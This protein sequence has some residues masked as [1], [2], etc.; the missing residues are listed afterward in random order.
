MNLKLP[1]FLLIIFLASLKIYAQDDYSKQ[2]KYQLNRYVLGNIQE[3]VYVQ[4]NSTQ[5]CPGDTIW[6]KASLANAINHHPV[7]KEKLLYVD[8][9]SPENKV[10]SHLLTALD[11]GFADGCISLGKKSLTGQYKLVAYTNYMRNFSSDFFFQKNIRVSQNFE[12]MKQW[13]FNPTVVP[14][15]GG[16]SLFVKMYS[17][18]PNEREF[19]GNVDISLQLARG[20]MFG[21]NCMIIGNS[22]SFSLFVPDSLKTTEALL[23]VKT[24]DDGTEKYRVPLTVI[25]PDLQFMPEG[26]EL[27]PGQNNRLA[28]RCVDVN[29]NPLN[30]KGLITDDS[31]QIT[32]PFETEYKGM[33]SMEITPDAG[34]T[35]LARVNYRDSVFTY[36]LP[37]INNAAFSIQLIRQDKDSIHF[38]LL[39]S[40]EASQSYI[41]FGH[42]RGIA[43]YTVSGTLEKART[44]LTV[45]RSYFPEGIGSFTLFINRIPRA[46]RLVFID[47]G[48]NIRFKLTT[49]ETGN[50]SLPSKVELQAFRKDGSPVNGNF[51]LLACSATQRKNLK[52]S[53]N[54]RNY[55]LLSSDIGG[56]AFSSLGEGMDKQYK[57]DLMLLT[58]GWRR[59]TWFDVMSYTPKEKT[60]KL[61]EEM[62][63]DGKV[64]RKSTGQPVPKGFEVSIVL[65]K[66][67]LK[68]IDVTKTGE[69][70]DFHFVLPA[71]TDSASFMIQTKNR[72]NSQRDYL[73]DI[74]TNLE[75]FHLT[76]YGFNQI[77]QSGQKP[78]VMNYPADNDIKIPQEKSNVLPAVAEKTTDIKK[79]RVDNYYFPGKDTIQIKDIEVRSD[80]IGKESFI[81]ATGQPDVTIKNTQLK[82]MIEDRP[83]YSS[84]WDLIAD[85]ITGL[86]IQERSSSADYNLVIPSYDDY[87]NYCFR[88]NEN[89]SGYLYIFVDNDLLNRPQLPLFDFFMDMDPA[90]VE[91]INFIAKPKRYDTSIR[92][93]GMTAD[94]L[95]NILKQNT[96]KSVDEHIVADLSATIA[97][98]SNDER[99]RFPPSFLFI[100][101][102]SGKGVFYQRTKGLRSL[103]LQGISASREFYMPKYV[104]NSS[105]QGTIYWYPQ[106]VT[107]TSGNADIELP[108]NV[109]EKN[110]EMLVQGI[111]AQGESGAKW[112]SFNNT[113]PKD[114]PKDIQ[115]IAA[116]NTPL[117]SSQN[118]D[119]QEHKNN[120]KKYELYSGKVVDSET[121]KPV[122]FA[123]LFIAAPFYH[124]C[125]N[126]SGC[127]LL[128]GSRIENT[129]EIKVY[130]PGYKSQTIHLPATNDSTFT[131]RLEK[132]NLTTS[133]STE[134]VREIVKD[135]IQKSSKL[136][137]S[138]TVFWGY[139]R[140]TTN[141]DGN[142]YGINEMTFNYSNCDKSGLPDYIRF[143]T[144]KFK[145]MEDK[146]GRPLKSLKP[147][148][149]SVF[150]PLSADVLATGAEFWNSKMI[151][152]FDYREAG[153]IRYGE[154]ECI[155]IVFFQNEKLRVS[156]PEGILFIGKKSGVLRY[157]AWGTNHAQREHAGY[158]DFLQANPMGHDIRLRDDYNQV[159]YALVGEKLYLLGISRVFNMNINDENTFIV[160]NRLSITG[161]SPLSYKKLKNKNAELLIEEGKSKNIQVK[162]V[163]YEIAPW[164]NLGLIKPEERLFKD[165]KYLHEICIS[166]F[167]TQ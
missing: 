150:H 62:H 74:N 156:L 9:I 143:E 108:F 79:S 42:C 162:N 51:S 70:G 118:N 89:P 105:K 142:L 122:F 14:C 32:I 92:T 101:T 71:F 84:I 114:M 97:A 116:D 24:T 61:S 55:L 125:T 64:Y 33:G 93:N 83:W 113:E 104:N 67:G 73:I 63:L 120:Y 8:L 98:H 100:T 90:D 18:M 86:K 46:E 130:A 117:S 19:N 138:E 164:V 68:Y 141:I 45:P 37:H 155:K 7:T 165:A 163:N 40:T 123:D 66:K 135:A 102:K 166:S 75:K 25:K 112:F 124:E 96:G 140:E 20:K 77:A 115:N 151:D 136:Y 47:K 94:V 38:A 157:A 144:T 58:F 159:S 65:L 78:V 30:I 145:N 35:Y 11:N 1:V 13:G 48:E 103:F 4:T 22:G 107:D 127:F 27:V 160:N 152:K 21:A 54:I 110:I 50:D 88:V 56:Q 15:N 43:K 80:Y 128:S 28:F 147:N 133:Q 106:L 132:A 129:N 76:P 167:R 44:E 139:N 91:S 121:G 17:Q 119:F 36:R 6:F 26:G 131:V 5:Y 148:H 31:K 146:N 81:A 12:S 154:E 34:K 3:K 134:K 60:Y 2:L 72:L 95:A 10:V 29:G 99:L 109:E 137:S 82:Q 23:S 16:D 52:T 53:E 59:F 158:Y 149:K 39:K 87:S 126:N 161:E 41:L 57:T 69:N 153:T 85:Q 111:S 49:T